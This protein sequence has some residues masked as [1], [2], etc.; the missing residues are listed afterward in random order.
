MIIWYVL[1]R[2]TFFKTPFTK[3]FSAAASVVL[4]SARPI[5]VLPFPANS[6]WL[7]PSPKSRGSSF[8]PFRSIVITWIIFPAASL[9]ALVKASHI[10]RKSSSSGHVTWAP[11]PPYFP[12]YIFA[13][14][15]RGSSRAFRPPLPSSTPLPPSLPSLDPPLPLPSFAHLKLKCQLS[16]S[17]LL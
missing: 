3:D 15:I 2:I 17:W 11:T 6:S 4:S 8:T 13:S 1:Y 9:S 5:H 7:L 14:Q 16:P 12:H 10:L